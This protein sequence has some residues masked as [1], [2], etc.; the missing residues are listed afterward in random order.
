MPGYELRPIG[1][2]LLTLAAILIVAGP[3]WAA[4][5]T[6]IRPAPVGAVGPDLIAAA[7]PPVGPMGQPVI[8]TAPSRR[9]GPVICARGDLI[10]PGGKPAHRDHSTLPGETPWF[11]EA[12]RWPIIEEETE[13]GRLMPPP[14]RDFRGARVVPRAAI[15]GADRGA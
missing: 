14:D 1:K 7:G 3:A 10:A 5:D 12:G 2:L 13:T 6:V 11:P 8:R 9:D 15:A 4:P